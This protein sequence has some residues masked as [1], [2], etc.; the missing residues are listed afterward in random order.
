VKK[1]IGWVRQ[2]VL[3]VVFAAVILATLPAAAVVS[4]G[5]GKSIRQKQQAKADDMLRQVNGLRVSFALP[6]VSPGEP[7]VTLTAAPNPVLTDWFKTNKERIESQSAE[8]IKAAVEF[9]RR[10]H[11]PL[12]NDL[13]PTPG[14][15]EML[16][17]RTLEFVDRIVGRP[18]RGIAGAYQRLF[19]SAGAGP[20]ADPQ[21][22]AEQIK[23]LQARET[24]RLLG[25]NPQRALT[26]EEQ[27]EIA[28][29]LV[30]ARLATYQQSGRRLRFY[31]TPDAV[32]GRPSR[33]PDKPPGVAECFEWQW[34]YWLVADL[35]AA[36][37]SA[38]AAD[39]AGNPVKRLESIVI[40]EPVV[41]RADSAFSVEPQ[42]PTDPGPDP[43][44]GLLEPLFLLSPSGR[45]APNQL[46]DTRLARLRVV[47]SSA[48]L[49]EFIDG[50][51]RTNFLTVTHLRLSEVD[52]WADLEQ[53]YF[54]GPEHV[55]RAEFEIE[56]LWLRAWTTP[57]M[58][59]EIRDALGV[60]ADAP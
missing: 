24:E 29:R 1:V 51:A 58:P 16:P 43:A 56:S 59:K 8:V 27:E 49:P 60:P 55:V 11:G 39:L 5:W 10:D 25:T 2:N 23:A 37:R 15:R 32:D 52:V 57:L 33:L 53:G 34:D 13:F 4:V 42:G 45:G 38:N 20:P 31:G 26:N 48:R 19:E 9:N 7:G 21:A 44:A 41:R 3:I 6:P 47:V 30:Q 40:V 36:I 28:H 50:L 18:D 12:I 54:Y 17:V 22:V 14:K 35:L 46:Y